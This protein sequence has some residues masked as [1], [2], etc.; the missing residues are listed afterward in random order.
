MI[1]VCSPQ[2]L[3]KAGKWQGRHSK[4]GKRDAGFVVLVPAEGLILGLL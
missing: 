1:G 2:R 3:L 4:C